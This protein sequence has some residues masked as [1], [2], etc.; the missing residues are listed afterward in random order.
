M[1]T[2]RVLLWTLTESRV[3]L[4]LDFL[5]CAKDFNCR[6]LSIFTYANT[7]KYTFSHPHNRRHYEVAVDPIRNFTHKSTQNI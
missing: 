4:I 3:N 7:G 6:N 5:A 2:N 1:G